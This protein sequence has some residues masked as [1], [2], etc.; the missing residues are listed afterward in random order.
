MMRSD[1]FFR[2]VFLAVLPLLGMT[3]GSPPALGQRVSV[4]EAIPLR[5]DDFYQ[6][7]GR[8]G[9]QILLSTDNGYSLD[10][11]RF[12]DR[13]R[14]V[15]RKELELDKRRGQILGVMPSGPASF[16]VLY[17]FS[18]KGESFLKVHRYDG[19]GMLQDSATLFAFAPDMEVPDCRMAMSEDRNTAIVYF[20][21]KQTW[22]SVYALDLR[23]LALLWDTR[24]SIDGFSFYRQ[25]RAMMV[26]DQARMHLVLEKE[27][28]PREDGA[29]LELLHFG[30]GYSDVLSRQVV[31]QG[32]QYQRL[33]FRYDNLNRRLAG[34]GLTVDKSP[35]RATGIVC[36]FI[37]DAAQGDF[38]LHR[39]P[40]R[41]EVAR[42]MT[43]NP[44]AA[45]KGL[46]DLEIRDMLLRT[47]G[48]IVVTVEESRRLERNIAG[49]QFQF[50]ASGVRYIVD[51]YYEDLLV[52]SFGPDGNP[53]WLEVL[54]KKQ[55]SQDDDGLYSSVFLMEA[56]DQIRLLYNDEIA[57]E[58]TV[59][60]Y[61]IHHTGKVDRTSVLSTDYQKL[62]LIFREACQTTADEVLVPSER[63]GR[64]RFVR[65]EF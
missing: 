53:D 15:G 48:G 59:S 24:V 46:E 5:K 17:V 22:L 45:L 65:I 47:D 18:R 57:Y 2:F 36:F 49:Q 52:A 62:K 61:R 32:I 19:E 27:R 33:K 60:A 9:D 56:P 38:E 64:I 26:D 28:K 51:Y 11:L 7:L 4:S 31:L 13:L 44:E 21:E 12:D 30:P 41:E 10:L 14:Q 40:F 8:I 34:V 23:R 43:G 25:F 1:P 16:V 35:D 58:N 55:Y 6:I 63:S 42:K 39:F 54:A 20:T 50:G 3:A 29:V 37:G